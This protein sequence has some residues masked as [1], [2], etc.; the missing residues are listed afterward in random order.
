LLALAAVFVLNLLLRVFYVRYDFVNGDEAMRALTALGL[1]EGGRLYVDVVT[2]KPPGTTF[3]YAATFAAFGPSMAAVHLAAIV[4]NFCTALAVFL[5]AARLYDRR[6]GLW[7]ATIFVYFSTNYLTQDMMAANTELLMILP[8]TVS[9][10]FF[11]QSDSG[12]APRRY[13]M[14]F[15]AGLTTG[16]AMLFKQVAGSNLIFFALYELVQAPSRSKVRLALLRLAAVAIGF[17]MVV[18][19]FLLWLMHNG[20]MG[21]FWRNAVL[22]GFQYVGSLPAETFFKFMIGRTLGYILFNLALWALAALAAARALDDD[23]AVAAWA[24][25]SLIGPPVGRRFFGHYFIQVL[26]PLSILAARGMKILGDRLSESRAARLIARALILATFVSFFRFHHRTAILAYEA[27]VGAR[28]RW[29]ES[30]GMTKREREVQQVAQFVRD[31]I[32]SGQPL[33]IWGYALDVYW[34]SGCRP[35]SRYLTPY[36]VTG[37]FYPEVTQIEEKDQFWR[38]ARLELIDDLRR[39]RPRLL[40]NTDEAIWSLPYPEIVEFFTENYRY[41]GQIGSRPF[42]VF[43][44][45]EE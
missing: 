1:L 33:Y 17:L 42:L 25:C 39:S 30:W 4:W 44:L 21:G 7:A 19:L 40:L 10:H 18:A 11:M 20:A 38:Q 35:A 23:L 27:A 22:L 45:K 15:L 32:G 29:S 36:Y 43:A 2:D 14:L 9:F 3:F 41:E 13:A 8:A 16:L 28:T 31:R 5:A 34:R 24:A 6:I 37:R 12:T 26:P